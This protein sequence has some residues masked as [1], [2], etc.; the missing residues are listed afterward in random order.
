MKNIGIISAILLLFGCQ[1]EEIMTFDKG[2]SIRLVNS[3][4]VI[5]RTFVFEKS[6]YTQDTVWLKVETSGDTTSTERAFTLEQIYEYPE[7]TYLKDKG[8]NIIDSVID[9]QM[10]K[11]YLPLDN[12]YT[13]NYMKIRAGETKSQIPIILLRHPDLKK[14]IYRLK[15]ELK[16]SASFAVDFVTPFNSCEIRFSDKPQRPNYWPSYWG[17]YSDTKMRFIVDYFGLKLTTETITPM[18]DAERRF[19]G[20]QF[21]K[22]LNEINAGKPREEWLKDENDQYIK[23]S[24]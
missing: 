22:K 13:S 16:S 4:Q 17:T 20:K 1:Q 11:H 8:G 15:L 7:L 18:V 9:A 24:N 12:P 21:Q 3:L 10:G 19:W 5:H 6:N 23:F 14:Q 2:A